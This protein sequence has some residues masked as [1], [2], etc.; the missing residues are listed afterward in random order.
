MKSWFANLPDW[1]ILIAW[2]ALTFVAALAYFS[3][4]AGLI[5]AAA[6]YFD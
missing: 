1:Q 3:P 2:L 5:E 6:G 4:V